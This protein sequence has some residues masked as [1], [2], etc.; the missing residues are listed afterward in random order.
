[1]VFEDEQPLGRK[2]GSWVMLV[3]KKAAGDV[4]QAV[5]VLALTGRLLFWWPQ[6]SA[7]LGCEARGFVSLP[8]QS[9]LLHAGNILISG[10]IP[11]QSP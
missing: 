11:N 3:G 4:E 8:G 6:Q 2:K 7:N 5:S 1:M 9:S 10:T